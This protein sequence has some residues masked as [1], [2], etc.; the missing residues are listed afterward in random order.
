MTEELTVEQQKDGTYL[1]SD[2]VVLQPA[3]KNPYYVL[4]TIYGSIR[5]VMMRSWLRKIVGFGMYGLVV[6]FQSLFE[7]G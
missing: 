5:T 7:T 2:G 1:R 3:E 6:E 4:A